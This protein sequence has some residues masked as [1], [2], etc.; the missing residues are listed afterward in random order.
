MLLTD[1]V[2]EA[3]D[4][5]ETEFGFERLEQILCDL[6]ARPLP[7]IFKEALA[8]VTRHGTQQDD[9]TLLLVRAVTIQ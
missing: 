9:Q 7:E 3:A 6:A 5:Q 2:V 4:G 1:G 8:A